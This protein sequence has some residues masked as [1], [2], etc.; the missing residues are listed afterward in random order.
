MENRAHALVAGLFSIVLGAGVLLAIWWLSG[1][2]EATRDLLLVTQRS[3]SGLNPQAQ[4]RFRGVRCGKVQEIYL[5]PADASTIVV[6]V[7][8]RRDIPIT[9]ATLAELKPQGITGLSYIELQTPPGAG[10]MLPEGRGVE[11]P[12]I[13]LKPSSVEIIGEDVGATLATIRTLASRIALVVSDQNLG[14]LSDTLAN[15]QSASGNLAQASESLPQVASSLKQTISPENVERINKLIV[16][17]EKTGRDTG[18][19]VADLRNLVQTAQ[20]AVARIDAVTAQAG[21]EIIEETLPRIH[22]LMEDVAQTTRRMGRAVERAEEAP[23]SF[24][25]GPP[26]PKP[27]PGEAGFVAPAAR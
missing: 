3:V 16:Q 12:R 24:I 23:Q 6:R 27:G 22:T 21:G 8:V 1:S 4:V 13:A 26:A 9:A 18:P 7:S 14:K 25:F 20:G 15:V 10:A 19:L 2:K 5:D 11:T 17:L